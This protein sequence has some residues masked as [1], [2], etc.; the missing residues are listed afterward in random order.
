MKKYSLIGLVLLFITSCSSDFLDRNPLDRPSNEAFWNTEKDAIAAANGCYNGWYSIYNVCYFDC[1]SDNAYNPFSWEGWQVQA[2]GNA[3]ASDTGSS[4]MSYGNIVRCNNFLENIDRP[5]MGEDLRKRLIAEVRFIRAW[6]YFLKVTLYGDVPLVTS[7]LTVEEAN[8]PRDSKETVMQFILDELTAIIPDLPASYDASNSGRATRGAA[9]TLK[10]R[11]E[12][13]KGDYAAAANSAKQV[14]DLGQY[15]L[16]D[17]YKNVF[18]RAYNGHSEIIMACE[19]VENL[20]GNYIPIF[21]G[22]NS[23]GLWASINPTQSLIDAFE[24]ADGKT[25]SESPLY[26][27]KDP[28]K[29]RDPRLGM[30]IIH[31]GCFYDGAYFNPI[32]DADPTG[33]YYAPYGRTKTGY[34]SR[35]YIDDLSDYNDVWSTD[36]NGIVMR[37]AEVL[38]MYAEGKIESNQIDASVYDAIN[39][40]RSRAGMPDV[41]QAVYNSQAKLR[42]LIRRER[43]VELNM[44]GLRWFDIC[45]WKIGEEVMPGQVW[46]ALLGKVD[47]TNGELTLTDERIK[48][49]VRN[50]EAKNY[51]WPIP[52]SVLDATPAI[53]QNEGY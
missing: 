13:F 33:D 37:Y 52:Q 15:S 53:K 7:V 44:E 43:R 38:L 25:I 10:G 51:L 50:F 30:S 6:H 29:N 14:M 20:S 16:V 35:K 34:H 48:V 12:L 41:D 26:N 24:C 31:P 47:P 27:A 11:M 17:N 32:D 22:P 39:Q 40:V 2:T 3:T 36:V 18:K 21:L 49:E 28:Y 42:E 4:F 46:G 23:S 1:A 8:L 19:Y 5:E 9:L 45:R